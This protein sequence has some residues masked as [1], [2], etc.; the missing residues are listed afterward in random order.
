MRIFFITHPDVVIDPE[1]PVPEWP[2]S[3]R[4]K[5]RMRFFAQS[6]LLH[7]V[8]SIHCSTERKAIDGAAIL[9]GALEIPY[10]AVP[11]LGENDRSA[12][13]YLPKAEFEEVANEFFA[14]P[15]ISVRGWERA[16]DAQA[17]IVS[18]VE[19]VIRGAPIDGDIAIVSHGGVGALLL[20][21]LKY[22]AIGR[23]TDQPPGNGG[24]YFVFDRDTRALQHCWQSIDA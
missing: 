1:V 16:V 5:E 21:H 14:R 18:A 22:C 9:S 23:G 24:N 6:P 4:G 12:T 7:H 11:A 20:A 13:G 17:R 2:L 19:G 3:P 8:C 15:D 10:R